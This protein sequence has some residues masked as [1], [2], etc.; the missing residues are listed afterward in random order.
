MKDLPILGRWDG[1]HTRRR[2]EPVRRSRRTTILSA[3]HAMGHILARRGGRYI[4][5]FRVRMRP[6]PKIAELNRREHRLQVLERQ[7]EA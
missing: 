2:A 1:V 4:G 6:A 3:K 7:R 5:R